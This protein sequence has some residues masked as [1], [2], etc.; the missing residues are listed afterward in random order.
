MRANAQ[1]PPECSEDDQRTLESL[2]W[3]DARRDPKQAAKTWAILQ[4]GSW[5]IPLTRE[6][7]QRLDWFVA[8]NVR[9]RG[10][11]GRTCRYFGISRK[12]FYRWK[13]R[14]DATNPKSLEDRSHRP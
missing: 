4:G 13:N 14:F 2:L 3:G 12:T 10:N 1:I 6:A 11:V 7:R 8:Y 9:F 5:R